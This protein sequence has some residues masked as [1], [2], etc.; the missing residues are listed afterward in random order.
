LRVYPAKAVN[1][2]DAGRDCARVNS[3]RGF[4]RHLTGRRRRV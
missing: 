1:E 2:V 3:G 4:Y